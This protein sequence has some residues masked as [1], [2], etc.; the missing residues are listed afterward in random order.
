MAD[1]MTI[2]MIISA[3]IAG[4]DLLSGLFKKKEDPLQKAKDLKAQMAAMGFPEPQEQFKNPYLDEMSTAAYQ[5][6]MNQLKRTSNW[7]W[8]EGM[9][10]D[11]SWIDE[12]M[13]QG[14]FGSGEQ[15]VSRHPTAAADSMGPNQLG[16]LMGRMT[17]GGRQGNRRG[18]ELEQLVG[19]LTKGR[20][21]SQGISQ[22][23]S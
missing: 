12:M 16:D 14:P 1:P 18:T 20:G 2:A 11:T 10:L 19:L 23:I 9:G 22:G 17:R 5:M 4:I 6:I 13:S 21:T 8:P 3:A 15:F 7:G